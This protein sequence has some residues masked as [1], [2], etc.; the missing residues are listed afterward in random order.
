ML[1]V[2]ASSRRIMFGTLLTFSILCGVGLAILY[3]FADEYEKEKYQD[4]LDMAKK[5]DR[6]LD[7]EISK[8]LL[9]LFAMSELIKVVGKWN[10]L[11]FKLEQ[12]PQYDKGTSVF[13]NV[14]GICDDPAY[15]DPFVDIAASIKDSSGMQGIIVNVQL[16]PIGIICLTYPKNNTRLDTSGAIGLNLF[17]TPNR[18]Y[19]SKATVH[20]GEKTIQGPIKLAQ[21]N[22]SVVDEAIIARY[23]V[24]TDSH[25]MT[26]DGKDYPFWGL[27]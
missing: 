13:N 17:D 1:R 19:T 11:P 12:T 10:N 20:K 23:P 2:A 26:V 25:N 14:T 21:G 4:A 16:A 6:W 3:I 24:F 18:A 22:L 8:A 7:K 27:T 15:R 9:P 5:A